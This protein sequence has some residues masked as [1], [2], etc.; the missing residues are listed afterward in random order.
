MESFPIQQLSG[1]VGTH[2]VGCGSGGG[3]VFCMSHSAA[4]IQWDAYC[5]QV[6][7]GGEERGGFCMS[8]SGEVVVM[9]NT[10]SQ[11]IKRQS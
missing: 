6:G 8:D 9:G 1:A 2:A 4:S 5:L 3:G 11:P 10:Q 7:W